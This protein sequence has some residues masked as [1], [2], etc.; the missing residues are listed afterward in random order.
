[1]EFG[2]RSAVLIATGVCGALVLSSC[3]GGDTGDRE[4]PSGQVVFGEIADFPDNLFPIISAGD[5][6]SVANILVH[7][8]PRAFQL[9]P[10]F[11]VVRDPELLIQEPELEE[12]DGKQV[13]VYSIN[14]DAIWSDRTSITADDFEF[15]AKVQDEEFI[16]ACPHGGVLGSTGYDQIES[17]EGSDDGKT[18]TVTYETPYADWQSLFSGLLPAHLMD[19]EDAA[20]LCATVTAGWAI[21]H[22]IVGEISGG[23]WQLRSDGVDVASQVVTL[24]PNE[25]YWGEKPKLA[26]LVY[27]TIG[28]DPDAALSAIEND[29]VQMIYY[30]DPQ[31]G[32]VDQIAALE[33]NVVSNIQF[34]L[35]FEHLDMN[36][37]NVHLADVNVRQ[38]FGMALDRQEIVD[39]TVAQ[40][41]R[42]AEVL[43][44]RIYFNSQPQYL[45]TAPVEYKAPDAAGA[46]VLL[47]ESGY[48][49]GADGVYEHPDRGRLSLA[50]STVNDPLRSQAI[51][52]I[53]PQAKEAGIEI[54]AREDPE[55]FAGAEQPTSL[56]AGGFDIALF[57]SVG[58]P[59]RTT[60]ASLYRS[61][62][63]QGG[64]QGQNYTHGG[65]PEVDALY[66]DF[67]S[68][69]DPDASA[70]IGN[71][72]DALL[73]GDLYTIPL[74]QR[75]TLL[76]YSSTLEGVD[77]NATE[78]GPLWNSEK[79]VRTA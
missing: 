67:L 75:P 33:P 46:K 8:L 64:S 10:D 57:A 24:I 55:I 42:D 22:G 13:N 73:W 60:T 53:I 35:A 79:W 41:S 23:P 45:D 77:D 29:E 40:F 72:I 18:V 16:E 59:V 68:E 26:S 20:E 21:D 15:T 36:T 52:V 39:E 6:T 9:L 62:E 70:E 76:A 58:S 11:S 31:L 7:I 63:A 74:Y 51:D 12:V 50:I 32:L 27:Q 71:E 5:A 19:S 56:E 69:P 2:K 17:I 4:G 47:E 3:D 61:L 38:A 34:G 43:N 54:V 49:L 65:N 14:S 30:P 48:L 28:N 1:M 78:A 66:E 25:N 37:R 44:N